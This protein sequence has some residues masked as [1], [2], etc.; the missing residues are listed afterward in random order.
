MD[1]PPEKTIHHDVANHQDAGTRH[2]PEQFL[3]TGQRKGYGQ[4]GSRVTS[5]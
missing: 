2:A 5:S 4:R 1:R 3:Y